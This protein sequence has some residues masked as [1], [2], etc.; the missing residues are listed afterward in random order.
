MYNLYLSCA[1]EIITK[2]QK[3]VYSENQKLIDDFNKLPFWKKWGKE[4][5][6]KNQ[7]NIDIENAYKFVKSFRKET[8]EHLEWLNI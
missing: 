8:I 4:E 7:N 6:I 3:E 2:R 1:D 5:I